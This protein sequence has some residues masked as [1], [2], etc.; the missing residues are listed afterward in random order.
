MLEVYRREKIYAAD[1]TLKGLE[2]G[3]FEMHDQ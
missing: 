1:R 2:K 3:T